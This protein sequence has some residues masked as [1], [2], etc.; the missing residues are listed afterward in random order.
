MGAYEPPAADELRRLQLVSRSLSRLG[1][2]VTAAS[3]VSLM[4]FSIGHAV[5]SVGVFG[6]IFWGRAILIL[7]VCLSGL[8]LVLV[9]VFD[10]RSKTGELWYLDL[11]YRYQKAERTRL[12]DEGEAATSSVQAAELDGSDLSLILK[13]FRL[14]KQLPMVADHGVVVYALLHVVLLLTSAVSWP[15]F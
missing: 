15:S 5:A 4:T 13:R 7:A 2:L 11:S 1:D 10:R 14:A 3:V 12:L 9:F 6:Y 8:A